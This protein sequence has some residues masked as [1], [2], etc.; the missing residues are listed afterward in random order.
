MSY[1]ANII[2]MKDKKFRWK[3][4]KSFWRAGGTENDTKNTELPGKI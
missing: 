2:T 4:F 3:F 1:Q